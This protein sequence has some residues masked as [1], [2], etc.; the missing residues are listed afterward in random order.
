MQDRICR[1]SSSLYNAA[2]LAGL[3]IVERHR[4]TMPVPYVKEGFDAT[5]ADK[6]LDLKFKNNF[7]SPVYISAQATNGRLAI[8]ILGKT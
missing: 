3:E 4:H 8:K 5:V 2:R 7:S 6:T 1:V